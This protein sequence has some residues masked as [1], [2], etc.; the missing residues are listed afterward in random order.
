MTFTYSSCRFHPPSPFY[1]ITYNE[2]TK[3]YSIAF[4]TDLPDVRYENLKVTILETKTKTKV[5]VLCLTHPEAKYTIIYSHG[6]ATDCGA[7]FV[8]YAM[9]ALSLKVNVVG[10][11]YTGYGASLKYNVRPTEKQTYKDIECVYDW[12]IET[13]LVKDPAKEVILY[14]QSV[15]SGPSTYLASKRPIAGLVLH[16][17][18]MSGLRVVMKSRLLC[19]CDIFPNINRITKVKCPVFVIHGLQDREVKVEHGNRLYSAGKIQFIQFFCTIKSFCSS[20]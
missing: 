12:C 20:F 14:G 18:I 7:M 2:E 16:S 4:S 1:E 19:C 13:K 15:G 9:I 11:D 10:Y 17:P 3:K 8:M 5:P 6:N